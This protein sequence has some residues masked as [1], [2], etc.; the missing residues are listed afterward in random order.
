MSS[1]TTCPACSFSLRVV[2]M[3]SGVMPEVLAMVCAF[4]SV[5]AAPG[6]SAGGWADAIREVKEER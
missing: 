1:T 3:E 5:S 4:A 2:E 6:V